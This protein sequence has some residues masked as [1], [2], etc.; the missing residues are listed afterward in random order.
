MFENDAN[1]RRIESIGGRRSGL[2]H[3]LLHRLFQRLQDPADAIPFRL[4]LGIAQDPISAVRG[5]R[6]RKAAFGVLQ[7][8]TV[9]IPALETRQS[10]VSQ[11]RRRLE[12]FVDKLL[13][14]K[15]QLPA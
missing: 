6:E 5:F 7:N 3:E 2:V 14:H 10:L 13:F 1:G 4:L 8:D 15:E 9:Y 11:I 12:Q